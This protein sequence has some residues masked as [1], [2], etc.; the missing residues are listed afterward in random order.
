MANGAGS[1]SGA[2]LYARMLLG[3]LLVLIILAALSRTR[4][5]YVAIYYSLVLMIVILVLGS[6]KRVT[7]MLDLVRAPGPSTQGPSGE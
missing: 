3:W 4:A 1:A 5:G 2:E 6:S 7:G